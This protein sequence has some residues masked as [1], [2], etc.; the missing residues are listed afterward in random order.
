MRWWMRCTEDRDYIFRKPSVFSGGETPPLRNCVPIVRP[1]K[2]IVFSGRRRRRPLQI[3]ASIVCL[4]KPF[5]TRAPSTTPWSPFL[6]EEGKGYASPLSPKRMS[7]L[8]GEGSPLPPQTP[9]ENLTFARQGNRSVSLPLEGKVLNEVKR[10]RC[11]KHRATNF[12]QQ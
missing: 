8:V 6:P 3:C 7:T 11:P 9:T 1:Q 5:V 2:P 10:M 12:R 4:Q